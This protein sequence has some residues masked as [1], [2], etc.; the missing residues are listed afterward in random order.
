MKKYQLPSAISLWIEK[1]IKQLGFNFNAPKPLA[2]AI[3]KVSDNY[4]ETS[5]TTPWSKPELQAAYL[6]YFFPLNYIRTLKVLDEAKHL[7]IFSEVQ[8]LIDYG[9]GPGTI[10]KALIQDSEINLK[11]IWGVDNM[12]EVGKYFLD[13]PRKE[14][15][16]SFNTNIPG[17]IKKQTALMASYVFNELTE[18]PQWIYQS[19]Q[20]IILE[21]STKQAS[22]SFQK[23]RQQLIENKYNILAPCPHHNLCPLSQSKKDWCHDRVYWE[24]PEWFQQIE[25]HLP[26]KNPSMTFSYLIASRTLQNEQKYS[27]VVGDAQVEK[28]KTKWMIC[29]SEEREFISFLKRYGKPPFIYRGEK[30]AIYSDEKKGQEIRI[31]QEN[32]EKL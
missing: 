19:D 11:H 18:I 7:G 5:S 6:S 32:F 30:L 2:Q 15:S 31:N 23:L 12:Q 16:L 4:Q 29:R 8:E 10:S 17:V 28:G 1:Y 27:R 22:L 9:C 20:I 26:M 24:Q 3:L 25:K 13:C 21:P 14:T